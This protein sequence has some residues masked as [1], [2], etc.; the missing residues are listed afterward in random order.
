M[1]FSFWKYF[2]VISPL[3]LR[4]KQVHF[5]TELSICSITQQYLF[6]HLLFF[7]SK[8]ITEAFFDQLSSQSDTFIMFQNVSLN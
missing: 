4:K 2:C 8:V 6:G 3:C 7:Y 1:S 5:S